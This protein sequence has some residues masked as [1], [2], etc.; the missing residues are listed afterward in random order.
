MCTWLLIYAEAGILLGNM[1]QTCRVHVSKW[2]RVKPPLTSWHYRGWRGILNQ[3]WVWNGFWPV[4]EQRVSSAC[5]GCEDAEERGTRY[6]THRANTVQGS[7][8]QFYED[9]KVTALASEEDSVMWQTQC[10]DELALHTQCAPP[11]SQCSPSMFCHTF[12]FKC[13]SGS[14]N[15]LTLS[16]SC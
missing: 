7:G 4:C 5:S 12:Y 9:E 8:S 13:Q 16:L 11:R 6:K 2:G 14:S 1:G 3:L 10:T 15:V